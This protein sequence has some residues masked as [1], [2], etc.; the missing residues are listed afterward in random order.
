MQHPDILPPAGR[1]RRALIAAGLLAATP[2]RTLLARTAQHTSTRLS[3]AEPPAFRRDPPD[4]ITQRFAMYQAAG[5]GTLRTSI[6]WDDMEPS[7]GQ[8]RLPPD[9]PYLRQA[10]QAGFSLKLLFSTMGAIP[11]WFVQARPDMQIR[12]QNGD[13]TRLALSYWH[14]DLPH[15]LNNALSGMCQTLAGQGV[16]AAPNFVIA[17]LGAAGEPKYPSAWNINAAAPGA[18]FW[19]YD[20]QARANFAAAMAQTY[21]SIGAANAAWGT[22]YSAWSDV[23][24]PAP[25]NGSA[26][27]WHDM[28]D[29]YRDSKRRFITTQLAT[30]QTTLQAYASPTPSLV[31]LL[32]GV[33][34]AA[35]QWQE[36][37]VEA[38]P[39]AAMIDSAFIISTA[40]K[41]GCMLQYTGAQDGDEVA[42]IRNYM[43]QNGFSATPLWGENAGHAPTATNNP[44]ALVKIAQ[45]YGLYGIEYVNAANLFETDRIT[46]NQWFATFQSAYQGALAGFAAP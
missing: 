2:T 5:V 6:G 15:V 11:A 31:A 29:W 26:P 32:P 39:T 16:I 22:R 9:M 13:T 36:S 42:W 38:G 17:D 7:D 30:Y 10:L 14:P 4:I 41:A 43:A 12:N 21:G 28:L 37:G 44:L 34:L 3:L 19:C 33:H 40:A 27:L 24:P 35:A 8:W 25:G 45:R 18:E 1:M 20:A 46:P 23:A